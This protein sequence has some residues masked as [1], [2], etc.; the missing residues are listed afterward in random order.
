MCFI[1]QNIG[2]VFS[3]YLYS[4]N[5]RWYSPQVGL[6][7]TITEE[8]RIKCVLLVHN[9]KLQFTSIFSIYMVSFKMGFGN[10][11]FLEPIY[12][13]RTFRI[14]RNFHFKFQ[15]SLV[16]REFW[17]QFSFSLLTS[18]LNN[19]NIQQNSSR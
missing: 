6:R 7:K 17:C 15:M 1:L 4:K 9:F 2:S 8:G 19:C 14:F 11:Q 10:F 18:S 3:L 12:N 5:Y 16:E 13:F